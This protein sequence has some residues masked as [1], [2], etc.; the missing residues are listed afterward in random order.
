MNVSRAASVGLCRPLRQLH[1]PVALSL[2]LSLCVC[3]C[4]AR[5]APVL[6]ALHAMGRERQGMD[7]ENIHTL[8][9]SHT[10]QEYKNHHET[11]EDY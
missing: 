7:D 5:P 2:S 10:M 1:T 3:V 8:V 9:Q 11:S 4:V 6:G